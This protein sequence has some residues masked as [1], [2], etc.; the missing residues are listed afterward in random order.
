MYPSDLMHMWYNRLFEEYN[1]YNFLIA[2]IYTL[3]VF[4]ILL[5]NSKFI[6]L[7]AVFYDPFYLKKR[8]YTQNLL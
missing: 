2:E 8:F 1:L 6:F 5:K 3:H 4:V 7:Y